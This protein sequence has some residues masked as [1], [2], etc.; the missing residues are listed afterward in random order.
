MCLG[1]QQVGRA[2]QV[3]GG[4]VRG[5]PALSRDEARRSGQAKP[6]P[7]LP[8]RRWDTGSPAP[9]QS[10]LGCAGFPTRQQRVVSGVGG[11]AEASPQLGQER[12]LIRVGGWGTT[13]CQSVK[14]TSRH[15]SNTDRLLNC[16]TSLTE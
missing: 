2:R 3:Q 10:P 1:A 6:R 14:G 15:L 5:G 13:G 7:L 4:E 11:A 9:P 12:H 8:T 16:T